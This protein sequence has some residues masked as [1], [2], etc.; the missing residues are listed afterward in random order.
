MN[1]G[2]SLTVHVFSQSSRSINNQ[3]LYFFRKKGLQ[4]CGEKKRKFPI[5]G[6]YAVISMESEQVRSSFELH[7]SFQRSECNNWH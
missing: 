4:G 6:V 1:N 3:Q 7:S 5:L 2:T